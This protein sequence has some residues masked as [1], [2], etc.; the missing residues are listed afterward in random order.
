MT[1]IKTTLLA[2]TAALALSF[3]AGSAQAAFIGA[4]PL[5]T[6]SNDVFDKPPLEGWYDANLYL[7]TSPS[8]TVEVYYLGKEAGY[9]NRF[10]LN[11]T[12]G[13]LTHDTGAGSGNN[14]DHFPGIPPLLGTVTLT[15]GLIDFSFIANLTGTP[16]T[17]TNGTNDYAPNKPNFFLTFTSGDPFA[18]ASW[19]STVNGS[20][21]FGGT[22]VIIALDDSGAGPDDNHDDMVILLR[23]SNGEFS[24]PEPASLALLGMGLLGLGFA[25]RRRRA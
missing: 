25:A 12:G 22:S 17:V 9:N 6:Q 10:I 13:T 20:T 14:A 11:H 24:V 2:G 18:L 7:F 21:P 3:A 4:S 5:G 1:T 23:I 16:K 8:A 19:D 15:A